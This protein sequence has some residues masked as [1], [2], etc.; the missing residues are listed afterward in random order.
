M[1]ATKG[2]ESDGRNIADDEFLSSSRPAT[3]DLG[4]G[5]WL[6]HGFRQR[7]LVL[8]RRSVSVLLA[9]MVVVWLAVG[10]YLVLVSQAMIA[11]RRVQDLR[12]ELAQL[13]E[14]NAALE[15]RIAEFQSIDRLL[16]A[17]EAEGFGPPTNVEFVVF[18]EE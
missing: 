9:L 4:L 13:Q 12:E 2:G 6:A 10:G 17:A 1:S 18:N 14:E 11:A 3:W 7:G 16:E 5:E 15:R 8:H